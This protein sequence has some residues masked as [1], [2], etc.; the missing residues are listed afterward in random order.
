MMQ[1]PMQGSTLTVEHIDPSG[2]K[3]PTVGSG[4]NENSTSW[5]VN[6]SVNYGSLG[7]EQVSGSQNSPSVE[8]GFV[9]PADEGDITYLGA[10]ASADNWVRRSTPV[11]ASASHSYSLLLDLKP[12]RRASTTS[13]V[14]DFQTAMRQTWNR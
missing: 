9:F 3:Y 2:A 4:A 11:A 8:A 13:D 12:Y 10:G 6:S 7:V 14:S 5:L 1:E